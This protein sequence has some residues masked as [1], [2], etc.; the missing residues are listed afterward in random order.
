MRQLLC[1]LTAAALSAVA[2]S[3][4][5][6]TATRAQGMGFTLMGGANLA[7]GDLGNSSEL[8]VGVSLRREAGGQSAT[9]GYRTDFSF[10]RFATKGTVD[11]FQ[12]VG[13]TTNLVHNSNRELYQYA[14]VGIFQAKTVPSSTGLGAVNSYT[15]SAF[16]LQGGVGLAL[17]IIS[18]NAFLDVGVVTVLTSGRTS[19]WFP[20]R[21]GFRI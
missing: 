20:I 12:Y 17:P 10:D 3:V 9:W 21:F 2:L 5:L 11:N 19:S 1:A 13:F 4:A 14:G 8:G 16:G 6:P 7:V 18:D 15:E